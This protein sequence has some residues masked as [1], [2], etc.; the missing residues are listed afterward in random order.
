MSDNIEL[1][2][3]S[4]LTSLFLT[5]RGGFERHKFVLLTALL[6]LCLFSNLHIILRSD[7]NLKRFRS[8]CTD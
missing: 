7:Y 3:L 4:F 2:I 1:V 6:L 5:F 8:V